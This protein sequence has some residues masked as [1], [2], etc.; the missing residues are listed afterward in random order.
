LP[1]LVTHYFISL[2]ICSRGTRLKY[3]LFIAL[4]GLLPDVD[5]I[6]KIHRWFT[7]SLIVVITFAIPLLII[8][9]LKIGKVLKYFVYSLIIYSIHIILDVF[10][11]STPIFWPLIPESFYVEVSVNAKVSETLTFSSSFNIETYPTDF[12]VRDYLE[13]PLLNEVGLIIAIGVVTYLVLQ[14]MESLINLFRRK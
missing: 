13:G 12:V 4:I 1:D 5:V 6:F 8:I 11:A 7:H 10:T 3:A 9:Y 14:N 2:L